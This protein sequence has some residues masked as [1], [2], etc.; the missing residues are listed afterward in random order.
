MTIRIGY[1]VFLLLAI[2]AS[3]KA[4]LATDSAGAT[5]V[6]VNKATSLRNNNNK[7]GLLQMAGEFATHYAEVKV[8]SLNGIHMSDITPQVRQA[9]ADS[10]ITSGTVNVLSTHT[11]AAITINE[12]EERLVDDTRQYLLKLAPPSYPYLHND[13][14]L[15]KGPPG[16]PGGDEAWRAQEPVNAHSH[17]LAML[18]GTTTTVPVHDGELKIGRWQSI[19]MVSTGTTISSLV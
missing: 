17:L 14:H 16:W 6:R 5:I 9:I 18:L 13:L 19:I 2:I 4:W 8:D 1:F 11:T 15:R 7:N 3:S 12:M 10:G